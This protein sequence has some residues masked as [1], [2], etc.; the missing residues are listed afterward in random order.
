M[1]KYVR[2]DYI[3]KP[4]VNFDDLKGVIAEFVAGSVLITQHR[5]TSFQHPSEPRRLIHIAEVEEEA[6]PDLEKQPFFLRFTSY[7]KEQCSTGPDV[8]RLA[9]VASTVA[10]ETV[11]RI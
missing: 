5:Y 9:P 3:V 8:T 11:S 6:I 7:L 4:E 10:Q 2:I 1:I